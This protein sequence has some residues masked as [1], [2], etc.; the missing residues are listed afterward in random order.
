MTAPEIYK[1]YKIIPFLQTHMYRVSAVA[2]YICQHAKEKVP[3]ENI[4]SA[5]LLHDLGNILKFDFTLFP[6]EFEPEGVLYWQE[7]REDFARKYGENVD[8][9]TY[10]I[11]KEIGVNG[12]T[13]ECLQSIG[14]SKICTNAKIADFSLEVPSYSDMRVSPFGVTSLLE[15]LEEAHK[16]YKNRKHAIGDENIYEKNRACIQQMEKDIF[17]KTIIT[18]ESVIEDNVYPLLESLKK[19]EI[20]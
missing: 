12:K 10:A 16:R 2:L 17:S 15:R 20:V 6:K 19:F 13:F 4:V 1:K 3:T 7:V 11:A 14:F 8:E 18:P 5:C 9:A